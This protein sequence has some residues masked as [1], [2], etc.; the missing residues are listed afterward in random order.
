MSRF[1]RS[2]G[3][4]P[5][6]RL[7]QS[8]LVDQGTAGRIAVAGGVAPGDTCLEIGPGLG[9]LTEQ[10]AKSA[11]RV[12]AVEVDGR[13][14]ELLRERFADQP[15]VNIVH[16]D[17]LALDLPELA[18]GPVRVVANIPYSITTPIIERLI[19]GKGIVRG[20][21]LLVQ[22][23]VAER[24]AAGPGSRDYSSLSV[25]CQLHSTVRVAFTVSRRLFVPVPDVDSALLILDPRDTGITPEQ[26]RRVEHVVQAGFAQRRK[27]LVNSLSRML[28]AAK[29]DVAR[30]LA[31]AGIPDAV[32]AE[33]V[34]VAGFVRLADELPEV[35]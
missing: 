24:I 8:F 9:A 27:T 10:L 18:G 31:R 30:A 14:A 13:F 34:D 32:R 33:D 11:S 7:G 20:A 16:S 26:E 5:S 17:F 35:G 29:E 28:P 21:A 2:R 19:R 12:I 4:H 22:R 1:L 23:E 25:F 15:A 3:I 6:R